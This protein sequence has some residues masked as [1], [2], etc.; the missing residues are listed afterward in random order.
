V[1]IHICYRSHQEPD[2]TIIGASRVTV[3][4]ALRLPTLIIGTGPNIEQVPL[5]KIESFWVEED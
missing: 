3:R 1:T 4:A 2:R 5:S